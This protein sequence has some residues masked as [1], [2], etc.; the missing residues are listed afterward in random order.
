[1]GIDSAWVKLVVHT[2]KEG[3]A[4]LY[5]LPRVIWV[6][7]D[8]SLKRLHLAVFDYFKE[9]FVRWFREID[10]KGQSNRASHSPHYEVDGKKL[11]FETLQ[12]M[13]ADGQIEKLFNAFFPKLSEN[14]WQDVL[15]KKYFDANDLPYQLKIEN[16]TRYMQSCH[17][18]G[19]SYCRNNCPL[20][21]SETTTVLDMLH[22]IGVEDNVSF[23][24]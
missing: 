13:I 20:P 15:E 22:K 5:N 19:N 3:Q 21:Y 23:Y 4:G 9:L 7:K 1:M 24:R 17:F 18:C 16:I 12:K 6:R 14:N 11:D 10:E 8:W 2:F